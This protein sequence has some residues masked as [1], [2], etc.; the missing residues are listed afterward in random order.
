MKKLV[1]RF[2]NNRSP[3]PADEQPEATSD[4]NPTNANASLSEQ[5]SPSTFPDGVEV[6]HDEPDAI[7]D[8]CFVHGLT[9][10]R[11]S[12]WRA[13]GQSE[14]WPKTLLPPVLSKA[15]ILTY[16]YDAYVV[17]KSVA[18]SNRLVDH[19]MNLVTDLTN[20][21]I[22]CNAS[23]RP[24]IFVAHSL[25]GLVC[26][27]AILISRNNPNSHRRE[28]FN[29]L[30]GIIF[31][32]TPHKGSW[33]ADWAVI[34][35]SALGLVKSA[36]KSLLKILET[37]DQ[38][39]ESIQIRFLALVREQ[40]EA[41]RHLQAACFFEELPLPRYGLVV[42][43]ESATFEGYDP[44]SIHAN[45]AD[46]VKFGSVG[47]TGFK[48]LVGELK[49]WALEIASDE[50]RSEPPKITNTVSGQERVS[51]AKPVKH[52]LPLSRNRKFVGREEMIESL[53]SVLFSDQ[54]YPQVALV[55]M[56]GMG[57]TQ[58]ALH[59]GYTVKN[60]PQK[61]NN[62]SVIWIPALSM[63]SFEQ[64]CRAIVDSW[65]IKNGL[66]D[67][68]E[69]FKAFFTSPQAGSWLLIIDNA[70]DINV[71]NGSE[72][73]KSGIAHFIPDS[74]SGRVLFTTRF[75]EVAV[76][77]AHENV[78]ELS[79]ISPTDATLLMQG[80]L[81]EKTQLDDDGLVHE[82]LQ[83]LTFLPL[84]I[85]QAI[86]YANT[87]QI[88]LREYLRLF[89]TT[90]QDMIE[91]LSSA[92][93]DANHYHS[94]QGA[95][96][97]TWIISFSQIGAR[98]SD[99]MNILKFIA[100]IEPKAIPEALLPRPDS[101][102]KMITAIGMLLG[103]GFLSRRGGSDI[104]DM[105]SLVHLA[106]RLSI[107]REGAG[108]E[109]LE[110]VLAHVSKV[111][112]SPRWEN[113]D[114]WPQYFPHAFRLLNSAE[115][116]DNK[117][118]NL[119]KYAVGRCLVQ[120][121]RPKE[122][123]VLLEDVVESNIKLAENDLRRLETEYELASAYHHNCQYMQAAK[124]LEHVVEIEAKTL[125][126][127]DPD[128]IISERL[129]AWTYALDGQV[130][131]AIKIYG[132]IILTTRTWAEDNNLRLIVDSEL[133]R[134]YMKAGHLKEAVSLLEK[135]VAIR[136]NLPEDNPERLNSQHELALAYRDDGRTK[137]AVNLLE[138]VVVTRKRLARD[139]P[140]LL[141]AQNQ[142][143][144]TY[145]DNGQVKEAI[146]LIKHVVAVRKSLVEDHPSRLTSE[147]ELARA[148]LGNGQVEEAIRLLEHV[149]AV[150]KSLA[151]DHPDRLGSEYTLARA[152][153][154]N[155]QVEE[156]IRLLEHAVAVKKSLAED[157]PERLAS[158]HTLARAYADNSKVEEAIQLLEHVVAVEKSLAENHPSRL[159]SEYQLAI[160]YEKNG[161]IEEALALLEHVAKV[162]SEV[163]PENHPDLLIT[164]ERL[165]WIYKNN[166]M[167]E[168]ADELKRRVQT[169]QMTISTDDMAKQPAER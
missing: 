136:R 161:Q 157:H 167:I 23:S 141:A 22:S 83:E 47:E 77:V 56:G 147:H 165:I 45:H 132:R 156:A 17:S 51:V 89:K 27:E 13:R 86:A 106:T 85:S 115:E 67:P 16:G 111:F 168:K 116:P 70:D 126:E 108:Q 1:T 19:A 39:L 24:L 60:N 113:H 146:K 134:T 154:D 11:T 36:N 30:K 40:R 37:D 32:G 100:Y 42:S 62:C 103:Y 120:D 107:E 2:R 61:Y 34:P 59:L 163:L 18:S 114:L 150:Q 98:N 78:I 158:E 160:T 7:V 155:G 84:A 38:L 76:Q 12:T 95:V 135:T 20:D 48:R 128:R 50:T 9:G 99:S 88:S 68:R 15:R 129:L 65:P 90:D 137:D 52:Y 122:G 96:A 29:R 25:G 140:H 152:Y 102:Q 33:M 64:A 92:L 6:L 54:E 21:R 63:A 55:G 53:T 139:H 142:L 119:L 8:I 117:H 169:A 74:D 35:V 130:Q 164:R 110:K 5:P 104:F 125:E 143:A 162:E 31:M 138:H 43:K 109:T 14:P 145:L 69:A 124:L 93:R 58:I 26:K 97:T 148:Y 46:M 105:H 87:N 49:M 159:I 75:R 149:V 73:K 166:N 112:P 80:S 81:V 118:S 71:L 101:E 44:V 3:N 4:S 151:E 123:V 127:D 28:I 133:G 41:G 82:L 131:N 72:D 94:A 144:S 10:S 121:G 91:L 153:L 66:D 79:Q 57:K